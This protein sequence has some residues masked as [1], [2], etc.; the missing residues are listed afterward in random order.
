MTVFAPGGRH[1]MVSDIGAKLSAGSKGE[2]TLTFAD[3]DKLSAP[4]AIS[5]AGGDATPGM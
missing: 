2:I 1:V 3:G 4:M 5:A